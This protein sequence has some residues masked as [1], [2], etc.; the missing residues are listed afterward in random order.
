M[1]PGRR[2]APLQ[3]AFPDPPDRAWAARDPD[4]CWR[5][6]VTRDARADETFVYAVKTTGVFCR[7]SCKA[8]TPLPANV[9]FHA[10]PD[11]ARAAGFRACKRCTPDAP[12]RT[13]RE[14]SIVAAAC[15]T[16]ADSETTPTLATLAAAAGLSPFHF[17]RLFKRVTG[18]TPRTYAAALKARRVAAALA[19]A[20]SVTTA[21]HDAGYGSASRFYEGATARLGMT[22]TTWR[23]GGAQQ[24]IRYAIGDSALGRALVA[25]TPRGVC[26]ILLGDD[27]AA[28]VKDL[29]KRF[30]K[31]RLDADDDAFT[32]IARAALAAVDLPQAAAHLPLDVRGTA[33]QERVWQELRRIPPGET[34]TYAALA[35]R[36]GSPQ[37]TRAVA[38][39]CAANPLAVVVPCHR[40]VRGDGGLGGYRWGLARK[41]ALL[42]R[43]AVTAPLAPRS[44]KKGTQRT[45]RRGD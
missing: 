33:F 40:V 26:A 25:T 43:E 29:S 24:T 23:K 32:G 20:P 6:V 2:T 27:D 15:A 39:A 13:A 38:S 35:N 28:L 34:L 19:E 1:P 22:P 42:A 12:S 37:A 11:D 31:A 16:L 30:P 5:A 10:S 41:E 9:T 7:P 3:D 44:D 36:I 17:Q 18:L 45:R 8:R 21:I 14:A 4:A